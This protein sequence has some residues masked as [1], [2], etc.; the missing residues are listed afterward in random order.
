MSPSQLRPWMMAVQGLTSYTLYGLYFMGAIPAGCACNEG[1]EAVDLSKLAEG[2]YY[3]DTSPVDS[4]QAKTMLEHGPAVD[5]RLPELS[6]SQ[7]EET[8]TFPDMIAAIEFPDTLDTFTS[9]SIDI[10]VQMWRVLGARVG[11]VFGGK[12]EWQRQLLL[13]ETQLPN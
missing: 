13:K 3:I 12:I 8:R 5:T 10:L 7:A 9:V 2:A 11:R 1:F 6:I 4:K